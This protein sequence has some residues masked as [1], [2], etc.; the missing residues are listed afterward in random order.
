M[1]LSKQYELI[2]NKG[3]YI[4]VRVYYNHAIQVYLLDDVFYELWYPPQKK[5]R[6]D[7]ETG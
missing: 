6:K 4:A 5:N 2:L 3:K 7:S 1:T